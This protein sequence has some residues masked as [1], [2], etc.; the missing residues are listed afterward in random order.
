MVTF[1]ETGGI[2]TT[3]R[4]APKSTVGNTH[5]TIPGIW[6]GEV[7]IMSF[8]TGTYTQYESDQVHRG[9]AWFPIRR[10]ELFITFTIVWPLQT[11]GNHKSFS[12]MQSF[13]DALRQH[14]Q[15]SAL[16]LGSPSPMTFTYY[17]N[18]GLQRGAPNPLI[19]NN[20]VIH[21]NNNK[22][23]TQA[24]GLN[25]QGAGQNFNASKP[26]EPL[27]YQGWIDTVEKEY[28]RFKSVFLRSYRMNIINTKVTGS[29]LIPNTSTGTTFPTAFNINVTGAIGAS[30]TRANTSQGNGIDLNKITG[31]AN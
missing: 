25:N 19:N 31:A 5:I 7:W 2:T 13:Q 4:P 6:A 12:T 17:N 29:T 30:W 8:S 22:L 18:T 24:Q 9:I 1:G 15:N 20:L 3:T 26:L 28:P 10:S 16:N 14:Q 23:L 11:I 21:G 27:I